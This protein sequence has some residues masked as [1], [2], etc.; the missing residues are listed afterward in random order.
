MNE[1]NPMYAP[2]GEDY[3]Q[4]SM[5]QRKDGQRLRDDP[6]LILGFQVWKSIALSLMADGKLNTYKLNHDQTRAACNLCGDYELDEAGVVCVRRD[7]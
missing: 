6:D 5:Y 3:P 2:L 1:P 4:P 7:S